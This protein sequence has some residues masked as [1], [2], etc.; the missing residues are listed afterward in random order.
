MKDDHMRNRKLKPGYNV[1]IGTENQFI[2]G[3]SIHQTTGDSACLVPHLEKMRQQLN[4]LPGKVVADAGY[5]SEENYTYLEKQQ[6]EAYVKYNTFDLERRKRRKIPEREKYWSSN[7]RYDEQEDE[8]ICPQDKR[9]IYEKTRRIRT[10]NNYLTDRRIYRCKDCR[11]CPVRALCTSSKY[12][13]SIWMSPRLNQFRKRARD[14]LQSEEGERYR[15]QRLVEAEAVFGQV[16]H[17][18]G[19]RRFLLRGLEKVNTEW[20]FVSIAHNVAKLAV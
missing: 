7:W 2:T 17:N 12:G 1:Q 11:D 13:R 20:G 15:S 14:R 9:L 10:N 18:R 6:I 3:Y 5:G 19:F 16:K 4:R 8:Y